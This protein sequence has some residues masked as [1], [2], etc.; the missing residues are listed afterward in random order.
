[1]MHLARQGLI[2]CALSLT[3]LAASAVN[4]IALG[5]LGTGDTVV[6]LSDPDRAGWFFVT[7]GLAQQSDVSLKLSGGDLVFATFTQPN[8]M[9]DTFLAANTLRDGVNM[10]FGKSLSSSTGVGIPSMGYMLELVNCLPVDPNV[11]M[12][13]TLSISAVPEPTSWALMA[14]GMLGLGAASRRRHAH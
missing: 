12:T 11:P 5:P 2:A 4:N 6:N 1:M 7:F 9:G 13:L 3:A 10:S 14:V 8:E